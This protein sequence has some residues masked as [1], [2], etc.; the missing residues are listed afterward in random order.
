[1]L[2]VSEPICKLSVIAPRPLPAEL[3][4][5]LRR[6]KTDILRLISRK[7]ANDKERVPADDTE[8]WL[9]LFNE[10]AAH[11]QFDGGYSRAEAERR[12]FNEMILEWQARHGGRPDPLRCVGCG[13][14]LPANSGLALTDGARVHFDVRGV[15]CIIAYGRKWRAAAAAALRAIG[16]VPPQGFDPL[17]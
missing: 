14:E 13:D 12:A 15:N 9:D 11:R 17:L 10:R 5:A 8:W 4:E 1:M 16:L 6:S 7:R 2:Q 3:V